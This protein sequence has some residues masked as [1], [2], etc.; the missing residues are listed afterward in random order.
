MKIVK[1]SYTTQA[2]YAEQN[3]SNIKNV[4]SDLQ[5]LN[6][7]GL[8]YNACTAA[9]GK[10]FIH[11]AFFKTDE[12]Q[13]VLFDLPSFKAFQEQLKASN[14]EVPPK[15]ELLTLIGSSMDIFKIE[16]EIHTSSI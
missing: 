14:P 11:T 1:V 12:D 10:T 6:H 8:N 7:P 9:D 15:Q 13:K 16:S 5:T 3:Q 4:M 2:A